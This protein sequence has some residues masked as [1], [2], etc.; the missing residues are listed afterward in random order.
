[1]MQKLV[2][3]EL[4]KSLRNRF[5]AAV[6]C[7]ALAVNF[8]LHCGIGDYREYTALWEQADPEVKAASPLRDF[9][10]YS[11]ENR[12]TARYYRELYGF[13]AGLTDGE[14]AAALG[15]IEARYG[16][17]VLEDPYGAL[18][19]GIDSVPGCFASYSDLTVLTALSALSDRNAEM[20]DAVRKVLSG[21]ASLK[22]EAEADGDLYNVRRNSEILRLYSLPRGTVTV[23]M[24]DAGERL[25]SAPTMKL[26]FLLLLLTAAASVSGERSR[27]TWALLCTAKNGRGTTLL[28]KY[29]AGWVSAAVL[30]A[31][32][33]FD[34]LLALAFRGALPVWEQPVAA[35]GSLRLCPYPMTVRQFFLLSL[36]LQTF[37]ASLFATLVT[38]VS[39][40]CGTGV[41]SYGIGALLLGGGALLAEFPPK[42]VWLW[43]PLSLSEPVRYFDGYFSC[44][45]FGRPVLWVV[46]H[47]ALWT[48]VA[49]GLVCL[50][51]EAVRREGRNV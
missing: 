19:Q 49:A 4:K 18:D 15:A 16:K 14:K 30:T 2:L 40:L 13:V 22:A 50:A 10:T 8:L 35:L 43:G 1:M 46:V 28:A 42:N 12:S 20:E 11:A 45:L 31:V 51:M 9:W 34:A 7:A 17:G 39:A 41:V 32:F 6:F 26:V 38:T 23:G 36:F 44:D 3:F 33:Q 47:L 27:G 29:A 24:G 48:A 37:S 21:A 5:F 25:F